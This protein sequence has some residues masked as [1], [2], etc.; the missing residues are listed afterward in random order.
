[1]KKGL[2]WKCHISIYTDGG[3]Q[4]TGHHWTRIMRISRPDVCILVCV[5]SI[6]ETDLGRGSSELV[7]LSK[8]SALPRRLRNT[9][10]R[11]NIISS[12]WIPK[13]I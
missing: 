4:M 6:D 8:G 1:M 2:Q 3:A 9:A 12:S 11:N 5:Y 7:T 13:L 10:A